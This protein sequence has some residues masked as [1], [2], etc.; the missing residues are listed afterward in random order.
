MEMNLERWNIHTGDCLKELKKIK[1]ESV[2][3]VVT[4]PPYWGLRDYG[5]A[6]WVGGKEDCD[7]IANPNATK[8]MGNPEFNENRPSRTETKT[9]GYYKSIC[10]KCGAGRIDSQV[11]LE[12][13]WRR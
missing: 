10:P 13:T 9:K 1:S 2:Q 8:K 4:S 7:H 12:D 6:T 11:G 3:T 5:T